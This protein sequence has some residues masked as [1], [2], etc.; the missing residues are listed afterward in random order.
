MLHLEEL[1]RL[2]SIY[3]GIMVCESL[4]EIRVYKCP[5][6]RRFPISLHMSED[7]EQASAPPALRIISGEEEWWESLEWDNPLTKTTLQ[8]FF[9][10]C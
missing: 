2:K 5:M 7:G 4:Q 8:P 6:L 9:S 1:P 3:K 10:S